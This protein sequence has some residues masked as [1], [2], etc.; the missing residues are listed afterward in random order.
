MKTNQVVL[1]DWALLTV[2]NLQITFEIWGFIG[3]F[4]SAE[5]F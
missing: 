4:L 5:S 1:L 3:S 2:N